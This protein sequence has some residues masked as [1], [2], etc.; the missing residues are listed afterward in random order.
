[1]RTQCPL[2]YRLRRNRLYK[3]DISWIKKE[4]KESDYEFSA[5]AEE[6]RQADK[7]TISEIEQ[8]LSYGEIIEDY[9]DD[10]RGA[11][12]LVLGYGEFGVPVH[13]VCGSTKHGTLRIITVYV[14]TAPKWIDE[15]TRRKI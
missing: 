15:R 11:S 13:M 10:P 9:L 2:N 5:H 7:L 4:I 6:E 8:A 12:C 14:P 1:M 3:M